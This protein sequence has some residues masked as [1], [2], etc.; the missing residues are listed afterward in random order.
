MAATKV[1][2]AFSTPFV[3]TV[4]AGACGKDPPTPV[5][6]AL[7]MYQ[8]RN[9]LGET[10]IVED[11]CPKN[12]DCQ[13]TQPFAYHCGYAM[14]TPGGEYVNPT[15]GASLFGEVAGHCY[16]RPFGCSSREC[17][18]NEVA[19][20]QR[21]SAP[22]TTQRWHVKA[23]NGTCRVT[24]SRISSLTPV[25]PPYKMEC[26]KELADDGTYWV[27]VDDSVEPRAPCE[28]RVDYDCEPGATCNP[29]SPFAVPC[30]P[31]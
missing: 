16:L 25:I 12:V 20:I 5:K 4:A 13:V 21:P 31:K 10:C 9:D 15:T 26:P 14:L 28:G 17:L 1:R 22:L 7:R 6:P 23:S 3:I 18:G 30:P 29:P 19:C 11:V 24:P 8:V 2:R 27:H